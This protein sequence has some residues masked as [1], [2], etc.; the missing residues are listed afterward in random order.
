MDMDYDWRFAEPGASLGVHMAVARNGEKV[1][2]ATLDLRRR[3]ITGTTLAWCLLR[4]PLIT[5]QVLFGIY[6]QAARLKLKGIPFFAHPGTAGDSD[7]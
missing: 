2:D 3:E 7:N 4:Y 6:W 1:F 5:V